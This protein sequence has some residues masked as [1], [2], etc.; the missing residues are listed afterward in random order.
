MR[1]LW[2]GWEDP[3]TPKR[4]LHAAASLGIELST[5]EIS[6]V[7]FKAAGGSIG[8]YQNSRNL[9][10]EHDALI[11]RTFYPHISEALTIARLFHD[12][13]K[14]VVDESLTDEGFV[15]SKMHD[16][17]LLAAHGIEVPRTWQFHDAAALAGQADKL[18]YPCVL[19]GVHGSH[20]THVHLVR[21]HEELMQRYAGYPAGELM[22]QEYLPADEDFRLLVVGYQALPLMVSRYPAPGD[23]RTNVAHSQSGSA[24]HISDF[25]GLAE[26]ASKAARILRREFAGV[27]I[28]YRH[29]KPV[30]L[31][32]NRRPVFEHFEKVTGFDVAERFLS[33]VADKVI[34]HRHERTLVA[35]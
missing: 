29:D 4:M 17:I 15:V 2:L 23:F 18:G 24:Y 28:R 11:A 27:D 31:E 33:Y 10:E 22:L 5:L 9:V 1:I 8:V 20:G 26:L 16:Y 21:N 12:A 14:V 32:V 3:Y 6:D 13:G 35:L 7:S 30:V 19:K 25:T 34:Q